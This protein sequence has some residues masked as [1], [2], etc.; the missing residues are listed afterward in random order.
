MYDDDLLQVKCHKCLDTGTI[1][2]NHGP[3]GGEEIDCDCQPSESIAD[4]EDDTMDYMAAVSCGM[5]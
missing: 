3:G 5:R 2:E 4:D 1:Y